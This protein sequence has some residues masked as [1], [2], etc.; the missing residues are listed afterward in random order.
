MDGNNS[1]D[2]ENTKMWTPRIETKLINMLRDEVRNNQTTGR[3]T[4]WTIRHWNHYANQ[5]HNIYGFRYTGVKVRQKYQRLK[6]GYQ[7]FKR[8]QAQ[9]GLGWDPIIGTV[10]APDEFWDKASRN[11][12]KFRTK[13]FE[14]FQ[15]M[16]EIVENCC[17]TGALSRASTQG[18]LD[19]EEEDDMLNKFWNADAG[20]SNTGESNAAEAIPVDLFED[21]Y[22]DPAKGKSHKRGPATSQTDSGRSKKSRSSG[23]DDVCA[24]FTSYVQAKTGHSRARENETEAVSA[25]G[26][27]YS[28]D[29]CQDALLELGDIPPLQY[30]RALTLFKDKEWRRQ[31][32]MSSDEENNTME[33]SSEED[34]VVD[35]FMDFL[36]IAVMYDHMN[37]SSS[38][39]DNAILVDSITRADLQFPHPPND[40]YYLVDAGFMNMPGFL[41]PFRSQRYHLQEFR[42][43]RYAGP[44]ELFNHRHSSLRNVIER[45]FGV[46]K[47]RFPI[48]WS[49]PNYKST[50][51][52]PLV[53]ACCVVHNWIRLHAVMDP[54]FME[55]DNEMAA[56]A[57]ADGFL[58]DQPDYVDMS[59]HGLTSQSNVRDAI[60]TAM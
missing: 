3:T 14:Y 35:D 37:A 56:E 22:I 38:A 59:Q 29:A 7:T 10:V 32:H 11:V 25:G 28:L 57:E 53:I 20:G 30:V 34:E 39:H 44:K 60:A 54:F 17:A 48:L 46:L 40:K 2:N 27:D 55:A 5:L 13:K 16:T 52:G 45:T 21:E 47:K 24:A 51:Q 49:M 58:G 41:A 36:M 50:R 18:P 1:D 26:D 15:E 31:R 4:S 33:L 12:K 19:S 43:H 42:G 9:T 23:F 8:L 6:A